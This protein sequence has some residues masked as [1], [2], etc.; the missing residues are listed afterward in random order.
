MMMG[1]DPGMMGGMDPGMMGGMGF[2]PG[3]GIEW[4]GH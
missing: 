3:M 2:D 4:N 1:M